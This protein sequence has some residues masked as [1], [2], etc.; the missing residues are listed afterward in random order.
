MGSTREAFI[1]VVGVMG[2]LLACAGGE[3]GG[4]DKEKSKSDDKPAKVGE[5]VELEDSEWEVTK[6]EDKG[7]KLKCAFDEEKTDGRFVWVEFKVK[8]TTKKEERIL[9]LPKL[10][11]GEGREFQQWDQTAM[12]IP[13]DKKSMMLDQLPSSMEKEFVAIFEVPKDAKD[14]TFMTRE[15]KFGGATRPVKLEL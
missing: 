2:V 3:N 15:L 11:D 5:E 9:D 1:Y 7:D 13:K 4:D 14:L 8:N 6:A 12:C 10:V